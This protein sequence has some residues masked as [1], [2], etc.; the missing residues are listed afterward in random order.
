MKLSKF[1]KKLRQEFEDTINPIEIKEEKKNK[2]FK[3]HLKFR[4]VFMAVFTVLILFFFTKIETKSNFFLK[5]SCESSL[6]LYQFEI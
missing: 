4:Y 1:N 6:L 2:S 3:F 5:I